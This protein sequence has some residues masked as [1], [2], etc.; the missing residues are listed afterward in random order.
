MAERQVCGHSALCAAARQGKARL[1]G[2]EIEPHI[3]TLLCGNKRRER[4]GHL[5]LFAAEWTPVD[6]QPHLDIWSSGFFR[7]SWPPIST[8]L[9]LSLS[10]SHITPAT[11]RRF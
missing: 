7:Q 3:K 4:E 10:I 1:N 2:Q 9:P 5:T 11:S 8:A 6:G